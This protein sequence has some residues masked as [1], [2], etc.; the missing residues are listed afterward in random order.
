MAWLLLW[1][2]AAAVALFASMGCGIAAPFHSLSASEMKHHRDAS[3]FSVSSVLFPGTKLFLRLPGDR[4]EDSGR[5]FPPPFDAMPGLT[6]GPV[7]PLGGNR[8][9]VGP[10]DSGMGQPVLGRSWEED[11]SAHLLWGVWNVCGSN[12]I[13]TSS[14]LNSTSWRL[15]QLALER[16]RAK[17]GVGEA[18]PEAGDIFNPFERSFCFANVALEERGWAPGTGAV[19]ID[20]IRF[21]FRPEM[22]QMMANENAVVISVVPPGMTFDDGSTRVATLK[23]RIDAGMCGVCP[24]LRGV[25]DG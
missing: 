19:F 24:E 1:L 16:A 5:S 20:V 12:D 3:A 18:L 11:I 6:G 10:P 17:R 15:H 23:D 22:D 14:E 8:L 9:A 2:Q 25:V 7:L 13:L 4:K 21:P